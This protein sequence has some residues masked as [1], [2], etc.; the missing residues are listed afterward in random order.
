MIN[1]YNHKSSPPIITLPPFPTGTFLP[2]IDIWSSILGTFPR[3]T[4]THAYYIIR[5][6]L[7][8]FGY[9]ITKFIF[10]ELIP[11]TVDEFFFNNFLKIL[12]SF[13]K[14]Y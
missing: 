8:Y 7:G 11:F 2:S 13:I 3:S 5:L 1:N 14:K 6:F 10:N 4:P 9:L 12:E